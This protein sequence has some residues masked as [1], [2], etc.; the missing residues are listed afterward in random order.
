VPDAPRRASK[1][2]PMR[3]AWLLVPGLARLLRS[4]AGCSRTGV[5]G[6]PVC[7]I[8]SGTAVKC[9]A[10]RKLKFGAENGLETLVY[11]KNSPYCEVTCGAC[12]CEF[13][14]T[15]PLTMSYMQSMF[16]QLGQVCNASLPTRVLLI[17]LG[18]G[19][20]AQYVVHRCPNV[21]VEAVELN[22]AVIELATRYFGLGET[23][24]ATGRISVEQDDA[25]NAVSNRARRSDRYDAV[26]VDCFAG[27]GVVPESCRKEAF[28]KNVSAVLNANGRLVQ[29]FWHFSAGH[30]EVKTEFQEALATYR[31]VF[32]VVQIDPVPMPPL[33]PRWV[34]IVTARK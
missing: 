27:N 2:H 23:K 3:G 18:G 29:N 10:Q 31:R 25:L 16:D 5:D 15:R 21:H 24:A 22:G 30:S 4:E 13:D 33:V 11:C 14:D 1:P 17:G 8:G 34:D 6:E 28:A 9:G 26:L 12:P 19:E 20:L 7:T 32:S